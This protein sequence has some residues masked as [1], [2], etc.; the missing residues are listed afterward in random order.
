MTTLTDYPLLR[1]SQPIQ[2]DHEILLLARLSEQASQVGICFDRTAI[3]NL[4]VALK[5]KPLVVLTGPAQSGKI[6]LVQVLAQ[7]LVERESL[8]VQ[9][10]TGHPWWAERSDGIAEHTRL[11]AR[12]STE[13]ILS[14]IE[15]AGQ[16]DNAHQVFIACLT[17]IS[18][19]ELLS[20]FTESCFSTATRADYETW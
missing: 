11:H 1:T 15:E 3:A 20:F 18:P 7:S 9:M 13:K 14:I 5:S 2:P 16:P 19:A 12:F 8:R 10:L 6:A 4:Y 17:Q